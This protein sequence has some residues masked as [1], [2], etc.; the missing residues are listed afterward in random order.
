MPDYLEYNPSAADI[1]QRRKVDAERKRRDTGNKSRNE[2][3][4]F[5]KRDPFND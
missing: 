3:G 2:H 4:Q 5:T 1:K